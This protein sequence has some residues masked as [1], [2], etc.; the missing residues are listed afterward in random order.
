MRQFKSLLTQRMRAI[1][2]CSLSKCYTSENLYL[3]SWRH[4]WSK[5]KNNYVIWFAIEVFF[6]WVKNTFKLLLMEL[7]S[8]LK[9]RTKLAQ[10]RGRRPT[11][12][13]CQQVQYR[14]LRGHDWCLPE[15]PHWWRH[16]F[17][18]ISLATW[19][20]SDLCQ[21]WFRGV[22]EQLFRHPKSG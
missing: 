7:T 4:F 19:R 18:A 16:H 6:P 15:H 9:I 20:P 8:V 12:G 13:R 11:S 14:H 5:L 21:K 2:R 17:L 1:A 10:P 22:T 3:A